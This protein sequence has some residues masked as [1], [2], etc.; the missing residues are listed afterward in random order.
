MSKFHRRRRQELRIKSVETRAMRKRRRK[1]PKKM[2]L[3]GY[4]TFD[5]REPWVADEHDKL[6]RPLFE[7]GDPGSTLYFSVLTDMVFEAGKQG[8]LDGS[9]KPPVIRKI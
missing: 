1:K 8:I 9:W 4:D 7:E 3:D 6:N 2:D 5:W